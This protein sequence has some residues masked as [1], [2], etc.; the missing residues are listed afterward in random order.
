MRFAGSAKYPQVVFCPVSADLPLFSVHF[1]P[2]LAKFAAISIKCRGLFF[3]QADRCGVC[4]LVPWRCVGRPE[5]TLA[6]HGVG[7][8][9]LCSERSQTHVY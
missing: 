8:A 6:A 2:F 3:G 1:R 5:I 7:R 9:L 4:L